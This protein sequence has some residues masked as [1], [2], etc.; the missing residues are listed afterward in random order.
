MIIDL[1]SDDSCFRFLLWSLCAVR[2]LSLFSISS[3]LE[4]LD[5]RS[6]K[7]RQGEQ[8]KQQTCIYSSPRPGT[9]AVPYLGYTPPSPPAPRHT[10]GT[11]WAIRRR[12]RPHVHVQPRA[13]GQRLHTLERV[14]TRLRAGVRGTAVQVKCRSAGT[15]GARIAIIAPA[16]SPADL[17]SPALQSRFRAASEPLQSRSSFS[18]RASTWMH[19]MQW[20][21]RLR[22]EH[23]RGSGRLPCRRLS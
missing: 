5:S 13:G 2:K 16:A 12:T 14:Y 3:R 9:H 21:R 20:N 19:S 22:C 7:T 23:V 8:A 18:S 6:R 17:P 15:P 1:S 10:R 4:S 11:V